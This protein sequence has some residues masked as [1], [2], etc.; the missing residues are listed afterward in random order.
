MQGITPVL[1]QI[2]LVNFLFFVHVVS[3]LRLK[4][5]AVRRLCLILIVSLVYFVKFQYRFYVQ[6]KHFL[7]TTFMSIE[8]FIGCV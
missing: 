7:L 1:R 3:P 2:A 8:H 6:N 5:N 4:G